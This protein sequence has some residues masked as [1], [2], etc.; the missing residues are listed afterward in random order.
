MIM[1]TFIGFAIAAILIC[2]G[3][4]CSAGTAEQW[5]GIISPDLWFHFGFGV[6]P[7]YQDGY[8]GLPPFDVMASPGI[9]MQLFRANGPAW[10]G[11]TG[12][13][14][15]DKESPIPAGG[16][17]TWWDISLWSYNYTPEGNRVGTFYLNGDSAPIGYWGHLVMDYVPANLNWTGGTDWWFPLWTTSGYNVPA[18][19]VP[20]TDD[21][22]NPDNVTRMHLTV[23][24]YPVPEPSSLAALGFA[25][26]GLLGVA[27]RRR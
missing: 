24:T 22:F 5:S 9:Y 23:Y 27:R 7:S 14:T 4:A 6:G 15:S 10:S 21:P 3:S 12:F 16:S 1:R 2:S 25:L 19:P 26:A 8:D 13:Y 18:L 17:H 20:T 11:P